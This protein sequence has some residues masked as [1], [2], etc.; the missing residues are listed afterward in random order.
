VRDEREAEGKGVESA[1]V[2]DGFVFTYDADGKVVAIEIDNASKRLR[3]DDEVDVEVKVFGDVYTVSMA[4]TELGAGKRAV[5]KTIQAMRARGVT[6]GK[7]ESPTSAMI[8]SELDLQ[9]I[10]QWR[11]EHP[12]G[13]PAAKESN[14]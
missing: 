8:L 10:R 2:S 14:E 13:R 4:A 11:N 5:A 9:A 1:E 6:V 7:Q 3:L 12:V